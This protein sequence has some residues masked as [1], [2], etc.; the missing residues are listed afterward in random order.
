LPLVPLRRSLIINTAF[1]EAVRQAK[2]VFLTA[3]VGPDGDTLGSML[4]FK[5]AFDKAYPHMTRIDS[6]VAGH[7]PKV[8]GFMP[9]IEAVRDA[10]TDTELLDQ[11]D[12]AISFDCGSSDR[13]GAAATLF[14]GAKVS[15]N[16]DHHISNKRFGTLNIVMPEA[17]ASG[18]VV[19]NLLDE[20]ELPLD[21]NIA[22]CL[23]VAILTDTGGFKYSNTSSLVLDL[24]ARLVKAGASPEQI[25]K[26]I[27]EERPREQVLVQADAL[28]RAQFNKD[29]TLAWTLVTRADLARFQ[30]LEEHVDGI[31]ESLRQI[32]SVLVSAVLKETPQ[33]TTKV[34]L[35][36][37][38][39]AIDVSAVVELFN[40]GGH[41]MAAGCSM[42]AA[43]E[44]AAQ[45]LLPLLEQAI[46]ARHGVKL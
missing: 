11:Y 32:D 46:L 21:A 8:Y 4:A 45:Q 23:Y 43:P 26:P 13:L 41:K 44:Q 20:L 34:S 29:A 1:I 30:A 35:R 36:S 27:Y 42:D 40:G 2:T 12:L 22:T 10:E 33:G 7:L 31:V 9:G 16:I 28:L 39:H 5:H 19:A 37:D 15:V 6:V 25:Y 38:D 18:Q 14:E 17:A 24:A 3:H